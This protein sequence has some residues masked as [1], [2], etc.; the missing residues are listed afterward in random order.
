[1]SCTGTTRPKPAEILPSLRDGDTTMVLYFTASSPTLSCKV[2]IQLAQVG[3]IDDLMNE[4]NPL[5][6]SWSYTEVT[7]AMV[8][9]ALVPFKSSQIEKDLNLSN[10]KHNAYRFIMSCKLV[11]SPWYFATFIVPVNQAYLRPFV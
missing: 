10:M 4:N 9:L 3:I 8:F 1:M 7:V 2:G 6:K 5:V 11:A